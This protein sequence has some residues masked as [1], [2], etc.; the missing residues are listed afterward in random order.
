MRRRPSRGQVA[1]RPPPPDLVLDEHDAI[2]RRVDGSAGMGCVRDTASTFWF[3]RMRKNSARPA[4]EMPDAIEIADARLI[5][6]LL[7]AAAEP[8]QAVLGIGL[9]A[10][11]DRRAE[12]R[13]AGD[14][15]CGAEHG[16]KDHL[17]G[18]AA[19]R[20][21]NPAQM[22]ARNVPDFV[23]DHAGELAGVLGAH[24]QPGVQE[25]VHAARDERVELIV[26]DDVD[27]H[28]SRARGP[29]PP[30]S[31]RRSAQ[32]SPRSRRPGSG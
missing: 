23:R 14:R 5:G 8:H 22:P 2:A 7:L 21:A 17:G 18:R 25:Q 26:V 6:R 1:G 32:G 24:E 31:A 12:R 9:P 29:R 10:R 11:D 28:R 4:A 19:L 30:G 3:S 27:A 13:R 16:G 15:G 20:A